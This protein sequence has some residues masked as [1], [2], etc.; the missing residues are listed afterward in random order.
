MRID[1][2]SSDILL[3]RGD[4]LAALATAFID[5][6][7]VLLVDAL[8]SRYD[9][10]EMRDYLE[11]TLNKKVSRIV[12]TREAG[13][14]AGL[15]LFPHAA[16]SR[17]AAAAG[18]LQWGR[19]AL[20]IFALPGVRNGALA[21]D[22][23]GADMLLAGDAVVGNL[24][25]LGGASPQQADALLAALQA[26]G[27][28]IVIPRN[29]GALCGKALTNARGYLDRLGAAVA[30]ARARA[31][32]PGAEIDAEIG[33]AIGAIE[34]ERLLAAGEHASALERYVHRDNL[35]LARER[36]WFPARQA[37]AAPPQRNSLQACC[38][39]VASVLT[40]MLG[41]LAERGV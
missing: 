11:T 22:V 1:Y 25:P 32:D 36:R 7:R 33:A 12:L 34:L 35:R 20:D 37:A 2:L 5:G 4:S 10:I 41:R 38:E 3:F 31:V 8:A 15:A 24:A 18:L 16:L 40:A 6:E 19:H 13:H 28:A 30:A 39:T 26:R 14:D 9:A 17:G 27:R 21:I 23:P 29:G